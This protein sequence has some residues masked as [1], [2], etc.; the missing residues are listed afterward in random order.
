VDVE[1]Y[2]RNLHTQE[3]HTSYMAD[4]DIHPERYLK[5]VRPGFRYLWVAIKDEFAKS[6][7]Q[8]G[9]YIEVLTEELLD[10][11]DLAYVEGPLIKKAISTTHKGPGRGVFHYDLQLCCCSPE[12]WNALYGIREAMGM[13]AVSSGLDK[14]YAQME[15][16]GAVGE[17]EMTPVQQ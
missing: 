12:T 10:N 4:I 13:K 7:I 14:F 9:R 3:Q 2:L 6:R 15:A 11:V 1:P 5:D 17:F 16:E 8:S